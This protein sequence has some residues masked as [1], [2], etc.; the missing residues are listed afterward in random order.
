MFL[1]KFC[2]Q[3][4]KFVQ[5]FQAI[6]KIASWERVSVNT[7][8]LIAK[9]LGIFRIVWARYYTWGFIFDSL[10]HFITKCDRYYYNVRQLFYYKMRQKFIAKCGRFFVTK[11]DSFILKCNSYYKLRQFDYKMWQL[12]QNATFIINC[13]STR[14]RY[15]EPRSAPKIH[16]K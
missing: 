12:L 15:K 16:F 9:V 10:W 11:R 2:Q 14:N 13:D 5:N 6:L 4:P 7:L 8:S 1:R 3:N